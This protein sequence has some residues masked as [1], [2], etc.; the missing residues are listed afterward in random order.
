M[1]D[2][3][4]LIRKLRHGAN[5]EA[6]DIG[7]LERIFDRFKS[8]GAGCD[9]IAEGQ[10]PSHVHVIMSGTACRYKVLP[11][12]RRAIVSLLLPGDFC[13]LHVA[14]LGHMDHSIGT[15]T[16]CEIALIERD[17][18]AD[19]L[20]H[21]PLINRACWWATLVDEA[22]LREWLVN[23]GRRSSEQQLAH[24]FCEL[25]ARLE[26]VGLTEGQSFFMPFT[27]TTLADLLGISAVHVQRVMSSLRDKGLLSLQDRRINLIDFRGLAELSDFDPV[28]LHLKTDI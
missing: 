20:I 16:D 26:T 2:E 12:G 14:I 7:R 6:E 3:N 5:L 27:Q 8:V 17:V 13:D 11:D 9:L 1:A 24:L 23:I 25:H 18:L 4:Y 21:Y 28:Y 10:P 15:L 22:V 19:M